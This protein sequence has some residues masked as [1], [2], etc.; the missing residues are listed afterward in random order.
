MVY[1]DDLIEDLV[2]GSGGGHAI[3]ESGNAGEAEV[4]SLLLWV[5]TFF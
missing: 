1:G 3:R 5:E 2:G 4:Q